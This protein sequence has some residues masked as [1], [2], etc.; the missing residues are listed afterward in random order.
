[1]GPPPT[2]KE[3]FPMADDD[4]AFAEYRVGE[5]LV[6]GQRVDAAMFM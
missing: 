1:M 3:V 6:I 4:L 2:P 5:G